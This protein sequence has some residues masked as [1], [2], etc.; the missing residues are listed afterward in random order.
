MGRGADPIWRG[1]MIIFGNFDFCFKKNNFKNN[2]VFVLFSPLQQPPPPQLWNHHFDDNHHPFGI[3]H[4]HVSL[5][6]LLPTYVIY[7]RNLVQQVLIFF[8]RD[9]SFLEVYC[10]FIFIMVMLI[11]M[12]RRD[13]AA[14]H[15]CSSFFFLFSFSSL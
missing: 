12:V 5:R 8:P 15:C 11:V 9:F 10:I 6:M 14:A 2:S 4:H 1:G 13:H 3:L 7:H